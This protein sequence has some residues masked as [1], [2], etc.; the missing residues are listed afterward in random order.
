ME[1]ATIHADSRGE[2]FSL[3]GNFKAFPEVSVFTTNAGHARGGCIHGKS[4]EHLCVLDGEIQYVYGDDMQKVTL[5]RGDCFTIEPN[6]PHYFVSVTDSLVMEWGPLLEEKKGK[7][8][9]FRA[10]VN[11]HNA[12]LG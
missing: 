8:P 6:V 2:I 9:A 12:K 4:R 10:I 5:K 3:T 11:E 1:L 7:H